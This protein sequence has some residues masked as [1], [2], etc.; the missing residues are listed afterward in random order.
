MIT[1]ARALKIRKLAMGAAADM[2]DVSASALPEM[3]PRLKQDGSLVPVGSR[4]NW[5]GVLRK[6]A[7]DLWD[8]EENSPDNA[9]NLWEEIYYTDGYRV[10]PEVI[11]AA[12]MFAKGEKGIWKG[13]VYESV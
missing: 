12:A 2:D 6:A 9:P 11:S 10:I 5:N 7:V 4:I 1:R 13:S 3:F 8:R